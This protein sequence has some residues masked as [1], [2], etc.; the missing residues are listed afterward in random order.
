MP[1]DSFQEDLLPTLARHGGGAGCPV[2]VLGRT[3]QLRTREGQSFGQLS[4]CHQLSWLGVAAGPKQV[5]AMSF[6]CQD[7]H[8]CHTAAHDSRCEH[9]SRPQVMLSVCWTASAA[10][11]RCKEMGHEQSH[12]LLPGI[13]SAGENGAM[14]FARKS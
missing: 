5:P 7:G 13:I 9:H 8:L 12:H 3:Q 14:H 4:R 11:E 1:Q 10:G 6:P 2:V